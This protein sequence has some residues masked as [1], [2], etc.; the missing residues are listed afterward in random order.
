MTAT[1]APTTSSF[2]SQSPP[3]IAASLER[4]LLV[5]HRARPENE[6]EADPERQAE[7]QA[8]GQLVDLALRRKPR[9]DSRDNQAAEDVYPQ[10]HGGGFPPRSGS[11]AHVRQLIAEHRVVAAAEDERGRPSRP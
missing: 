2:A 1:I 7:E 11:G 8:A 9:D 4:R 3:W 6:R 10:H 5:D